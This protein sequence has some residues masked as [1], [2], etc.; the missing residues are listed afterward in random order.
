MIKC[1][2]LFYVW[3][4]KFI[5]IDLAKA[6]GGAVLLQWLGGLRSANITKHLDVPVD[7]DSQDPSVTPHPH[8][9]F[10]VTPD[11]K[12]EMKYSLGRV[13]KREASRGWRNACTVGSPL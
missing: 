9:V 8:A 10:H 12:C 3:Q 4:V 5:S 6:I 2:A 11:V 13:S 1:T 7:P